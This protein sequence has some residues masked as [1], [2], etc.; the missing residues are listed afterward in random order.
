MT[1]LRKN[2]IVVPSDSPAP[3]QVHER[4]SLFNP[5]GSPFSGGGGKTLLFHAY[6]NALRIPVENLVNPSSNKYRLDLNREEYVAHRDAGV[7]FFTPGDSHPSWGSV[8]EGSVTLDL[9][10]STLITVSVMAQFRLYAENMSVT[11]SGL[12][13]AKLKASL[14]PD[15]EDG[16]SSPDYGV[17]G[18]SNDNLTGTTKTISTYNIEYLAKVPQYISSLRYQFV[19]KQ[20][21]NQGLEVTTEFLV[22]NAAAAVPDIQMFEVF[23]IAEPI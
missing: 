21:T 11:A 16:W 6:H 18:E 23:V 5:D 4:V 8:P 20:A 7:Q 12:M 10:P 3:N 1:S 14:F 19:N 2:I 22:P 15:S 9:P 17:Y 13:S